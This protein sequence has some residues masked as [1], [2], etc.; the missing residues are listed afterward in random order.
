MKD[1]ISGLMYMFEKLCYATV[2]ISWLTIH[3]DKGA[4]ATT[5]GAS[6]VLIALFI[7]TFINEIFLEKVISSK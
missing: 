3:I 6:F 5:A 2:F 1:A 7:F 4:I